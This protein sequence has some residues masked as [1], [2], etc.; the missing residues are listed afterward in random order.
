M[1]EKTDDYKVVNINET[2]Y[3]IK[4]QSYQNIF[5]ADKSTLS[6]LLSFFVLSKISYF[7]CS[8]NL[9]QENKEWTREDLD[10]ILL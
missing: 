8:Q 4:L 10:V 1:H 6:I 9:Q 7:C 5:S 2:T 3:L